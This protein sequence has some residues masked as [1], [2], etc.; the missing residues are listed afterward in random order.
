MNRK[1]QQLENK[2]YKKGKEKEF[3]VP[4]GGKTL[5]QESQHFYS[6]QGKILSY[7]LECAVFLKAKCDN[8]VHHKYQ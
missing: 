1:N 4:L 5:W 8:R 6:H 7:W 3:T 2:N